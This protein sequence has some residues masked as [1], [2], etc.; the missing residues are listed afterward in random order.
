MIPT[1]EQLLDLALDI[2]KPD[3]DVQI[4]WD[5]TRRVLY[6]HVEGITAL[7]ICQ[8]PHVEYKVIA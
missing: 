6:V 4:E 8:V 5:I 3:H 7:R 2:T 1:A